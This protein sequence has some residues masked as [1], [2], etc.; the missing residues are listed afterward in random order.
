MLWCLQSCQLGGGTGTP[1]C[2]I[3]KDGA[4][5]APGIPNARRAGKEGRT[6]P[7]MAKSSPSITLGPEGQRGRAEPTRTNRKMGGALQGWPGV[8]QPT[9]EI[10]GFCSRCA[11]SVL[12]GKQGHCPLP[13]R[14]PRLQATRTGRRTREPAGG[15]GAIARGVSR[16]RKARRACSVRH[17][18]GRGRRPSARRRGE[19]RSRSR[20]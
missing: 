7:D 9:N 1:R 10:N 11:R 16:G 6:S 14:W 5:D 19:E 18:S 3:C 17:L 12:H 15:V 13:R 4:K 2:Y 8:P 20:P